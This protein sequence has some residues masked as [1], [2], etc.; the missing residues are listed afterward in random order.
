MPVGLE[1]LEA[2]KEQQH[3]LLKSQLILEF[4]GTEQ[5]ITFYDLFKTVLPFLQP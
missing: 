2:D 3:V 5:A 1:D 4:G